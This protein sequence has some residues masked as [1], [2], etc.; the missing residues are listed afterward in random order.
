MDHQRWTPDRLLK[1]SGGYW[2]AC[3]LHAAVERDL[4]TRI[5]DGRVAAES[6]AEQVNAPV[7]AVSRLLDAV[8][9]MGLL[10]KNAAGYANTED[11]RT[12]LCSDSRHYIGYIIRH[13]HHL[14]ASWARLPEAVLGGKPMRLPVRE[15]RAEQREAFLMGM[16]NLA[17]QLAPRLVPVVDL[18]GSR[19][20]LDLGGG[21]G[22]YAIH[23][24]RQYPNLSATVMDLASTRPFAEKT[25][26]KMDMDDR[27]AFVPGDY[28]EDAV[29][30]RYDAVW[31]SHILH[32]ET[33]DGCGRIIDKAVRCLNPGGVA[34]VHEFIL[35][36]TG[37]RPLFPALFSLNMLLATEGGR[38]YRQSQI[39]AMLET[40]GLVDIRR[41]DFTGPNDSGIL[42]GV[43]P[44]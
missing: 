11:S 18:S 34:V 42:Q 19:T 8:A 14:M 25:I 31:M 20:L 30:G 7:D 32:G 13:H 9:A 17:M 43:K 24:C 15:K 4:F 21:P 23:F 1:T 28:L 12:S 38:A 39:S 29:P 22:T 41:L 33:A 10:T 36:D 5:G 27:V 35:D 3:A 26:Q 40:A 2:A 37:D 16:F 44:A 6:I